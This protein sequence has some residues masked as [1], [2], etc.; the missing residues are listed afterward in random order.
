MWEMVDLGQEFVFCIG[1]ILLKVLQQWLGLGWVNGQFKMPIRAGAM[2]S[3]LCPNDDDQAPLNASRPL[4]GRKVS[5]CI[6]CGHYNIEHSVSL[7]LYQSIQYDSFT[8]IVP[9][10]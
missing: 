1:R 7:I 4:L 10:I 3:C 9:T 2:S 6:D 8:Y 5:I